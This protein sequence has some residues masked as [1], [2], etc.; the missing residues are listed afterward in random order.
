MGGNNPYWAL[1]KLCHKYINFYKDVLN[2][3][4][5]QLNE[6]IVKSKDL[7]ISLSSDLYGSTS[8]EITNDMLIF[9]GTVKDIQEENMMNKD[10]SFDSSWVSSANVSTRFWINYPTNGSTSR[11]LDTKDMLKQIK[12]KCIEGEY[13]IKGRRMR[14]N[15]KIFNYLEEMTPA[16]VYPEEYLMVKSDIVDR[17]LSGSSSSSSSRGRP[18]NLPDWMTND[19]IIANNCSRKR[20][21]DNTRIDEPPTKHRS[22]ISNRLGEKVNSSHHDRDRFRYNESYNREIS[23]DNE[24][25]DKLIS[26]IARFSSS[27]SKRRCG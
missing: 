26:R 21:S 23:R 6:D 10:L 18:S 14:I 11:S 4:S 19:P 9:M 8:K 2:K 1:T 27:T 25:R 5:E 13:V 16:E 20:H 12:E 17:Y 7:E 3:H 24:N 22:S 15:N